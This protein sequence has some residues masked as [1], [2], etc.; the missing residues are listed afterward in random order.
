MPK[1]ISRADTRANLNSAV[2]SLIIGILSNLFA[3]FI[4]SWTLNEAKESYACTEKRSLA[5][6]LIQQIIEIKNSAQNDLGIHLGACYPP[7]GKIFLPPQA[8]E[9]WNN[10]FVKLRSQRDLLNAKVAVLGES[11]LALPLLEYNNALDEYLTHCL[12][13]IDYNVLW[14]NLTREACEFNQTIGYTVSRCFDIENVS[15]NC[16]N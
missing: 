8:D 9:S 10:N 16:G 11:S 14:K 6:E 15:L 12:R 3:Y 5:N 1:K 4:T 2:I 13:E 7:D